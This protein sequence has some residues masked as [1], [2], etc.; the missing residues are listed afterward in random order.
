[1]SEFINYLIFKNKPF[2]WL[3]LS[4]AINLLGDAISWTGLAL[5]AYQISGKEATNVLSISLTIRVLVFVLVAPYAGIL[6]DKIDRKKIMLTTH[7]I[8]MILVSI[9]PFAI[10]EWHIYLFIVL[11]SILHA[12]FTPTYK[13]TLPFVVKDKDLYPKAIALSSA[14]YQFLGILGPGIAG[15]VV[16]FVSLKYIFW[17]DALTFLLSSICIILIPASLKVI[18]QKKRS[19]SVLKNLKTGTL[20]L[21]GNSYLKRALLM[22]LVISII[23]AQILVNTIYHLK[24]TL[25]LD[26]GHYGITM[27]ILALG[28]V[29]GSILTGLLKN[30]NARLLSTIVGALSACLFLMFANEYTWG[31]TLFFWALIGVSQSLVNIPT[32]TLIADTTEF[33]KQGRVYGAHFAW[34]HLWWVFGY[35]IA[36]LTREY[37]ENNFFL[38]GGIIGVILW[39]SLFKITK[40][41]K[42]PS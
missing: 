29:F 33:L 24:E 26:D 6:A 9:I 3:Y 15:G 14:T 18:E 31:S 37:F 32:D 42:N 28:A 30:K 5:L 8:R 21:L 2:R 41:V 4:Q 10:Y 17:I 19:L 39:V 25:V 7:V 40:F 1:M 12:L 27:S 16:V 36:G 38:I 34:S 13:A 23:G 35:P 11:F 22:Q 20:H